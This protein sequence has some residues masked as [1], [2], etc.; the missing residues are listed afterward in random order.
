M[1][2]FPLRILKVLKSILLCFE[3]RLLHH[4]YLKG[5]HCNLQ[6]LQF[7]EMSRFRIQ[8][9]TIPVQKK[10]SVCAFGW[11]QYEIPFQF[12]QF[13]LFQSMTYPNVKWV[14]IKFF[15]CWCWVMLPHYNY[16]MLQRNLFKHSAY[17][18]AC[19]YEHVHFY[20][21]RDD[22]F[23]CCTV[24]QKIMVGSTIIEFF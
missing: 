23:L 8:V 11:Y 6:R 3:G 10:I 15:W 13:F 14:W 7:H 20:L 17:E 5:T 2:W 16:K 19:D 21:R 22:A 18:T 12:I 9:M 4:F 24:W 1:I